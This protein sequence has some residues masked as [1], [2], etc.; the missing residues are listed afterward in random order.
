LNSQG[1]SHLCQLTRSIYLPQKNTAN[2]IS[3]AQDLFITGRDSRKY[4]PVLKK[5]ITQA[6]WPDVLQRLLA[7]MKDSGWE[8][9]EFKAEILIEHQMWEG[10]FSLCKK[11]N[12]ESIE[13]YEK[14]LKPHYTKEIFD[15]YF[16]YVEKQALVT[17]KHEERI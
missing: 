4:Y 3:T 2:I 16:N 15:A 12:V 6:E 17:D 1:N 13:K 9:N 5:H 11:A 7:R 8:V 10:L 14:Y